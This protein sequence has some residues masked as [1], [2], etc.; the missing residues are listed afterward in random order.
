MA[1]PRV[2]TPT[3]ELELPSTGQKVTFRPFLVKEEKTLLMA[4]ESPDS[5]AMAKAMRDIL[6]SC[7]E[8]EID[9]NS[10]AAFDIEYFFLQLRGRSVGE[11]ITIHP[12][13][14]QNFKCCKEAGEEDICKVEIN[15]ED[16]VMDTKSIQA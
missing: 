3:Y 2:M 1:L 5:R 12:I 14:P 11:A 7:T 8:G 15:L 10:L 4:M 6:T 13:R 9:L 16:I